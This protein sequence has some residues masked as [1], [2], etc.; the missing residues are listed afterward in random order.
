MKFE[1]LKEIKILKYPLFNIFFHPTPKYIW[2]L[3]H[4]KS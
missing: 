1:A 4:V 2:H 3:A